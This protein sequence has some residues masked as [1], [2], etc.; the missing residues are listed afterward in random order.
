MN[1]KAND[2]STCDINKAMFYALETPDGAE[3]S[4]EKVLCGGDEVQCCREL[5]PRQH[6]LNGP[7]NLTYCTHHLQLSIDII[8]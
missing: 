7:L 5:L 6:L 8:K 1:R 3:F 2:S 4:V